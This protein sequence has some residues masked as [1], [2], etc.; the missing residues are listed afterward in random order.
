MAGA[1][2]RSPADSLLLS[3]LTSSEDLAACTA[4]HGAAGDQTGENPRRPIAR[5]DSRMKKTRGETLAHWME[6]LPRSDR[7]PFQLIGEA[8]TAYPIFTMAT[9]PKTLR[10]GPRL[11]IIRSTNGRSKIR[12]RRNPRR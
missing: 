9:T 8:S 4:L 11:S 7:L 3:A 5:R 12:R 2:V 10:V 6:R 1:Q